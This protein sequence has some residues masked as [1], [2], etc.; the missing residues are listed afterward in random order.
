MRELI[1]Q[2]GAKVAVFK[3]TTLYVFRHLHCFATTLPECV[4][5]LL[6]R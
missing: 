3:E 5:T 6:V 1:D 2:L 4:R